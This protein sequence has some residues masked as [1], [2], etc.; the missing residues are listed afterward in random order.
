MTGTLTGHAVAYHGGTLATG[1]YSGSTKNWPLKFSPD[2]LPGL[3]AWLDG[4]QLFGV[5]GAAVNPWPNLAGGPPGS[6]VD[7]AGFT[8]W[9]K[10]SA[11]TLNG[12]PLVR[13]TVSEGR[14]RMTGLDVELEF[15]LVYLA[16]M[17]PGGYNAGRMVT[18][19]YPPTNF[20]VGY[21]NGF[22]DVAYSTSGAFWTPDNR[23]NATTNWKLYSSDGGPAASWNPRLFKNGVLL[24]SS[25][26]TI[27]NRGQD[28]W[29][30][31]LNLSGYDAASSAE[32]CDFEMA[33]LILYNR[34]LPDT[35]RAKVEQYMKSK[36]GV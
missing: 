34:K 17:A 21:W 5:P 31:T 23:P 14:L 7:D 16:R 27:G 6:M 30:G 35:D 13:F 26:A 25:S 9:P 29:L 36:W 2:A 4:S 1:L 15:T 33:E 18:S 12:H 28:G 20:L 8:R 11:N 22:E 19:T 32:T 3:V 24:S 10:V